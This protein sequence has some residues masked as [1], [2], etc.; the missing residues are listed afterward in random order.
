MICILFITII[1]LLYLR[2]WV[3]DH[4]S[5]Q[6]HLEVK[7]RHQHRKDLFKWPLRLK[8]C[9]EDRLIFVY[10]HQLHYFLPVQVADD[11]VLHTRH[12]RSS[13]KLQISNP[14]LR[15]DNG[16]EV[17]VLG[18]V[19]IIVWYWVQLFQIFGAVSTHQR[20]PSHLLAEGEDVEAPAFGTTADLKSHGKVSDA[21]LGEV[22]LASQE[23]WRELKGSIFLWVVGQFI[24]ALREAFD[25]FDGEGRIV[26]N[27]VQGLKKGPKP[28]NRLDTYNCSQRLF[29]I[30][31]RKKNAIRDYLN[32][33]CIMLDACST[34]LDI[35]L[36]LKK[37]QRS[38]LVA[39]GRGSL[40]MKGLGLYHCIGRLALV[41]FHNYSIIRMEKKE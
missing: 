13:R 25:L 17:C 27:D 14:C 30:F 18:D 34:I 20:V 32:L 37:V 41:C 24:S 31:L 11:C 23:V 33:L 40:W 15:L 2:R 10:L 12:H 3:D 5:L 22:V 19:F 21:V 36:L 39:F 29:L 16:F 28:I 4:C 9:L 1:V 35:E 6:S 8:T 38:D 26:S 7:A